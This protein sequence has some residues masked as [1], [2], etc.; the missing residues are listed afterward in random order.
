MMDLQ[1]RRLAIHQPTFFLPTRASTFLTGGL[2]GKGNRAGI[3]VGVPSLLVSMGLREPV[4]IILVIRMVLG[5]WKTTGLLLS[6][7]PTRVRPRR[8][9]CVL[10]GL[11]TDWGSIVVHGADGFACA[12]EEL[13]H[14]FFREVGAVD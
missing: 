9:L 11:G 4:I 2:V 8:G 5:L 14:L 7:K 1:I 3:M 10:A 12:F 6:R 13:Y